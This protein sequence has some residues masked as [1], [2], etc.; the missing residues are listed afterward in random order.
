VGCAT[1]PA[2][3]KIG[4]DLVE[5]GRIERLSGKW[6]RRFLK[7]VF[8]EEELRSALKRKRAFEH[9]AARFAAKEA[10]IKAAGLRPRWQKIEVSNAS[11]GEPYFSKL[12]GELDPGRVKLSLSHTAGIAAAIVLVEDQFR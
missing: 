1:D 9:L 4:L 7:R 3:V 11:S 2:G 12:P 5:V 6:G 8:T 10:L